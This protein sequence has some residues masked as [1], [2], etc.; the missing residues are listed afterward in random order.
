MAGD[1]ISNGAHVFL[2]E[3]ALTLDSKPGGYLITTPHY[4]VTAKK[5]VIAVPKVGFNKIGGNIA[6]AIKDQKQFK[7]LVGI[8]VA[9]IAQRWPNEWWHNIGYAGKDIHR[10]WTTEHCFN[11]TEIPVAQ[12]AAQQ[13]VTR[14]VYTDKEECVEFW[15]RTAQLGIKAVEAEIDR[16][17]HDVL[18]QATIPQPLNTVVKIWPAAWYWLRGGS[19]FTNADIAA[20]AIEPLPGKQVSLVGESY[21]PQRSGW[22]DGA[23]KSS[24]NT[25]NAKYGMHIVIP[26]TAN[27]KPVANANPASVT[28]AHPTGR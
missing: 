16:G 9:T 20:W 13:L 6:E 12:Y 10:I 4:N 11:F 18:P 23:Y 1:A 14:T 3:P 21:N 5:L 2:N 25:L 15:Q 8:P 27:I 19:Q 28:S 24:I 22:S 7:D 26:A 17:L